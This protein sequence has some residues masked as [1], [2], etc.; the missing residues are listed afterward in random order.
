MILQQ[1]NRLF[2]TDY[3][4]LHIFL[5]ELHNFIQITSVGTLG[6]A[7]TITE[8]YS[9]HDSF[10]FWNVEQFTESLVITH[11]H[12]ES[13]ESHSASSQYQISIAYS[14]VISTPT[15]ADFISGLAL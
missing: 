10:V 4:K 1:R 15:V 12:N 14:I 3:V 6:L 11:T 8:C 13:V 9:C 7:S 5:V 2:L